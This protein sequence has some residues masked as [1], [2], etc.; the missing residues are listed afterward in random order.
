MAQS[1]AGA[2]PVS[3]PNMKIARHPSEVIVRRRMK[4]GPYIVV[5]APNHP[6]AMRRGYVYEH[7]LI[8]ERKLGKFL[9][10][11]IHVHHENEVKADNADSNLEP[12]TRSAHIREHHASKRVSLKCAYCGRGFTRIK[13][14]LAGPRKISRSF[15]S[16]KCKHL[17]RR[18]PFRHGQNTT[19]VSH[20]CRCDR[21]RAAHSRATAKYRATGRY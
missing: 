19:Y 14:Q 12:K 2:S 4:H 3:H 8:V 16:V 1:L 6:N 10:R 13:S 5:H 7:R 15:C 17:G 11:N 21:C 20:G 18:R 9:P